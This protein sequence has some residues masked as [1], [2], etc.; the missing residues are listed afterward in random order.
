MKRTAPPS[1]TQASVA[2][3]FTKETTIRKEHEH[4]HTHG[5]SDQDIT[6]DSVENNLRGPTIV[7]FSG[8]KTTSIPAPLAPMSEIPPSVVG[9]GHVRFAPEV[10]KETITEACLV[11]LL[12]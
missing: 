4:T 1:P 5:H 2:P 8:G 9:D 6:K 3:A 10:V 11:R 12:H 7:P